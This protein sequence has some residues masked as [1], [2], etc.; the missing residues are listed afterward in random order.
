MNL[1]S[2]LWDWM[3]PFMRNR[4][5][6]RE[7]SK[8]KF[9]V[10]RGDNCTSGLY[11]SYLDLSTG[12]PT[13]VPCQSAT[14]ILFSLQLWL[15]KCTERLIIFV[16]SPWYRYGCTKRAYNNRVSHVS[17]M[18]AYFFLI[19]VPDVV[20]GCL[21][22]KWMFALFP[23][24]DV[25]ELSTWSCSEQFSSRLRWLSSEHPRRIFHTPCFF[26]NHFLSGC[27]CSGSCRTS[28]RFITEVVL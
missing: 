28:K 9:I 6:G 3:W 1:C 15:Y 11:F 12:I 24:P 23:F 22:V 10:R 4:S 19:H 7:Y 13:H 27:K 18:A 26:S 25:Y 20:Y 14:Q 5:T 17:V 21:T 16:F 8:S 2:E